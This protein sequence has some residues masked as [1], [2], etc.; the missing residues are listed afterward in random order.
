MDAVIRR[1]EYLVFSGCGIRASAYI[2]FLKYL[3]LRGYVHP[4]RGCAGSSSGAVCALAFLI[5]ADA[6]RLLNVG[7]EFNSVAPGLDLHRLYHCYGMDTGKT[8]RYVLRR[9]LASMDLGVDTTFAGLERLTGK[10]LIVCATHL[11][12]RKPVYFS[13]DET[14]ETK[15]IDALYMS[16]TIPF[17]FQPARYNESLFVDGGLSDN[18]PASCFP[19]E[20]TVCFTMRGAPH[21]VVN[22]STYTNAVI[23][24][25]LDAQP[26]ATHPHLV[27]FVDDEPGDP[28]SSLNASNEFIDRLVALGFARAVALFEPE[29]ARCV[30]SIICSLLLQGNSLPLC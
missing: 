28:G 17:V 1:A 9:Q 4:L 23:G 25:M 8:L 14:P 16:M 22:L 7:K 2:G 13:S 24:C 3:Q 19:P 27:R 10:R 11:N 20:K 21:D 29:V 15:L 6:S 26:N 12:S 5:N 30:T 18:M